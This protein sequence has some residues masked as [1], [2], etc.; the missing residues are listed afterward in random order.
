[1]DSYRCIE[2]SVVALPEG[3]PSPVLTHSHT[4]VFSYVHS[5]YNESIDTKSKHTQ[6]I[7]HRSILVEV[8]ELV[9]V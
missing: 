4:D 7:P 1:M 2:Q 8:G 3:G 5:Y 9:S 6:K